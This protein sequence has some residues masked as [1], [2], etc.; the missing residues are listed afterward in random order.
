M[1]ETDRELCDFVRSVASGFIFTAA[2][3]PVLA[4]GA[5][6]IEHL[7]AAEALRARHRE[8]VVKVRAAFAVARLPVL[9]NS[10][11]IVPVMVRD[12][13]LCKRISDAL[14]ER[15]AIYVQPINYPTVTR[16]TERLRFTPPP[17][18]LHSDEDIARLTAALQRIWNE[19]GL[20]LAA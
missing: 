7:R 19:M 15:D 20:E 6:S 1:G 8:R 5:A 16:G 17:P 9:E 4:A 2:L 13:V 18:L 14:L 3:P 10:S 12:P 11:H